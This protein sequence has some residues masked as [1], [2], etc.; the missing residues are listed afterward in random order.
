MKHF[1]VTIGCEYGS[2]GPEIGKMIADSL[3]IEYYDRDL[4]DKVVDKLGVDRALVEKA[5]TGDTVKYEFDTKLGPRY[6][7]LT[8]RVIYTQFEV[9]RKFAEKSSCVIIGRCSD[10]ILKERDDCLN[11]FI[12]AP[13]DARIKHIMES[14]N[15]SRKEAEEVVKYNDAMLH[16]RYKYMTGTYRGDRHMRHMMIDSSVLGLEKT[17]KYIIQMIDL[18]FEDQ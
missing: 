3:G 6:A 8:N 7:N 18:K 9:I 1:V 15:L 10:Y 11:V 12:Y 14:Q 13:E 2:G 5:D 17:A 4:V 16:T